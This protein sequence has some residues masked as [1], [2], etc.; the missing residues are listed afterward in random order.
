MLLKTALSCSVF[1]FFFCDILQTPAQPM[2]L[3]GGSRVVGIVVVY[4]QHSPAHIIGTSYF[5]CD[6]HM[7]IYAHQICG[8]YDQLGGHI[9]IW[10]TF[11]N[12]VK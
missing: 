7:Y 3:E 1:F 5:I 11:G 6:I 8:R 10:H 12:N 4:V 9:W 2:L